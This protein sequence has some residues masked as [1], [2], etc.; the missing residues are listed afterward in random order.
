MYFRQARG[1]LRDRQLPPRA[2]ADRARGHPPGGRR[3]AAVDGPVHRRRLRDRGARDGLAA[4][5]RR[6]RAADAHVQ[7]AHVVHARRLPAAGRDRRRSAGCGSARR[8]GSRTRA[9][10]GKALAELMTHGDASVDL[11]E[12]DPE[13][14]DNHGLEPPVRPRP[15]RPGLPRGLRHHPP[16]PAVRA[17]P[18]PAAHAVLRAR[19]GP[20]RAVLRER[21]LGAP[22]VVRGQRR[23]CSAT[24]AATGR[25]SEWAARDWSPIAVA[26]HRACRERVGL[27]DVSPFTKVEV[28]GPGARRLPAAPG[29]QRRR[30]PGRD[31]RLHGDARPARRDHVR[32][33]DHARLGDDRYWVVT[34]GG[35]GKHDLAWMRRNL[36]ADGSVSLHDRTSGLCCIGVW[37]PLARDARPVAVARTTCRARRSRT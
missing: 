11:H 22:A 21:R 1:R 29:G 34:G 3:D 18:R 14:Y 20:R 37:G 23:A 5:R 31:D 25:A 12:A 15:R 17:G 35:V 9:A 10:A 28:S 16:A 8:S 7:R 2:A 30:P 27:F 6:P 36:P 26:E 32:P 19:G 13:R 33:D 24:T 4:A